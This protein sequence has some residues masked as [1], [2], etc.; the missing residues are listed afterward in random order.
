M[1]KHYPTLKRAFQLLF[2]LILLSAL[3]M[4]V[5]PQPAQAGTLTVTNTNDSGAGSLRQAVLD[6]SYDDT[7]IFHPSLSGA[8]ITLASEISIG[9]RITIDGSGLTSHVR[10]SGGNTVRVFN[11]SSGPLVT[12][13]GLAIING[14]SVFG[15]GIYNT[16]ELIVSNCTLSNND[17]SNV[18]GAIYNAGTITVTFSTISDNSSGLDGGGIYNNDTMTIT[19]S[20]LSGNNSSTSG[21]GLYTVPTTSTIVINST[22]SGNVATHYGCGIYA[23][24]FVT[25]NNSTIS[26]NSAGDNG[27]GVYKSTSG[28]LSMMRS[29]V[30]SSTSGEDCYVSGG[31]SLDANVKNL[32]EDGSCS[33]FLS[34]DPLL[35]S[36]GFNSGPT[37]TLALQYG[38]PAIDAAGIGIICGVTDQRG[39]S[40]PQGDYCD[41]G[42]YEYAVQLTV[43]SLN[44]PGDGSCN[45]AECTLREAVSSI[46]VDGTINID[47]SLAGGLI[48]LGSEIILDNN[49][50]LDGSALSSNVKVS[51]GGSVRVFRVS[52]GASV[53]ID[54]LDIIDGFADNGGG[55]YNE[56]ALSISHSTL[57]GNSAS[58]AGGG[59][60]HIGTMLTVES[61]TLSS[62]TAALNGGGIY[63]H[64]ELTTLS[65]LANSTFHDN[66]TSGN[67]GG[68][69]ADSWLSVSNSTFH[70]NSAISNGGGIYNLDSLYLKNSIL[71]GSTSG[72]DCHNDG[73]TIMGI[74]NTLVENGNCGSTFSN[75]PLL[76]PLADNGGPTQ[77]MGLGFGSPA[78][79]AGDD[80]TCES[81]DQRGVLR[82]QGAH[83][84]LG[85]VEMQYLT[86]NSL[87]DPGTGV[88]DGSECTLREAVTE[89]ENGSTIIFDPGLAG[90]TIALGSQ[91]TLTKDVTIDGSGLLP[92]IQ[93]NGGGEW[94]DLQSE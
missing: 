85:A 20:T 72:L 70:G 89:L 87:N 16:G 27:G 35:G 79:N 22:I 54:H 13:V 59:I 90:G 60:Y 50:T 31:G 45:T 28:T 19:N 78:F 10:I 46:E 61:S 39:I 34:G 62:N 53:D 32:I 55:I 24:G 76:L 1:T 80:D 12:L 92:K 75:D 26:G 77:T 73:G 81:V 33:P 2:V 17:V 63:D 93:I 30:A 47:P 64:G 48:T 68:V 69:Y 40:R 49:M 38:S 6:A 74:L 88:C 57:S 83:C 52:T 21:G 7:I 4:S 71:A 44:E 29:I 25:V 41:I 86:V 18:G 65:I 66:S 11:V 82:P 67:G 14:S 84:D 5:P 36:L 3:F 58:I 37:Q 9:T 51:G 91:I 43:N 15:G 56:G 94:A 8:T 42:A 23:Y